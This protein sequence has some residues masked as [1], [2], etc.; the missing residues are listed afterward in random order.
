[1]DSSRLTIQTRKY[2]RPEPVNSTGC[3]TMAVRAVRRSR[4]AL[5]VNAVTMPKTLSFLCCVLWAAV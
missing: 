5:S 2:S 1:M 4:G 3:A